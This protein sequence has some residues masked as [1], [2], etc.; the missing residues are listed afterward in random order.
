[1]YILMLI[2]MLMLLSIPAWICI[3]WQVLEGNSLM[4]CGLL[5]QLGWVLGGKD[6]VLLW[7]DVEC[8]VNTQHFP[9]APV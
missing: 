3:L 7:V 5:V 2:I 9:Q 6:S 1:M 8:F 4:L